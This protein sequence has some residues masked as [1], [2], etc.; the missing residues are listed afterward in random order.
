MFPYK[1]QSP[2]EH[3]RADKF[4]NI[5]ER[6]PSNAE[7]S[8]SHPSTPTSPTG[9]SS[10]E[11]FATPTHDSEA[12]F[13]GWSSLSQPRSRSLGEEAGPRNVSP[14]ST[15][16]ASYDVNS[17]QYTPFRTPEN[18]QVSAVKS[19]SPTAIPI[20]FRRP[21]PSVGFHRSSWVSAMS[22][23][24]ESPS[25]QTPRSRHSKGGST[26]F[27]PSK[28]FRPLYLV[29]RHG[30]RQMEAEDEEYPPLPLSRSTTRSPSLH[31]TEGVDLTH[32][33]DEGMIGADESEYPTH[34]LRIE[35]GFEPMS[36]EL[37]DSEQT[38]PKAAFATEAAATDHLHY[39]SLHQESGREVEKLRRFSESNVIEA[40][41]SLPSHHLELEHSLQ[42]TNNST[43]PPE[44]IPLP[45]EQDDELSLS[46][47]ETS[48]VDLA[49]PEPVT[50]GVGDTGIERSAVVDLHPRDEEFWESNKG[51]KGKGEKRKAKN[52]RQDIETISTLDDEKMHD[53]S[54]GALLE[55]PDLSLQTPIATPVDEVDDYVTSTSK[56][57]K[58]KKL[59][60][61]KEA[62]QQG[63]DLELA[64]TTV[65]EEVAREVPP[66]TTTFVLQTP[67]A[68][69]AAEMDDPIASAPQKEDNDVL[70]DSKGQSQQEE[71][72][73]QRMIS[74]HLED[75]DNEAASV[76]A[77]SSAATPSETPADEIG[78]FVGFTS[79]KKKGKQAKKLQFD[80]QQEAEVVVGSIA[81]HQ[82]ALRE[83]A[84]IPAIT[85]TDRGVDTRT[86]EVDDFT[87]LTSKKDKKAKKSKANKRQ[88]SQA[89]DNPTTD[90]LEAPNDK[91]PLQSA[92]PSVAVSVQTPADDIDEFLAF[93][94]KKKGKQAKKI[95]A[96]RLVD[97]ENTS[98]P[99][100]EYAGEEAPSAPAISPTATHFETPA[101]EF[102]DFSTSASKK[103]IRKPR[104][105]RLASSKMLT[106]SQLRP[107]SLDKT[108]LEKHRL[109][110]QPL[111]LPRSWISLLMMKTA[112]WPSLPRKRR[113]TR[114]TSR[115]QAK[116]NTSEEL[117]F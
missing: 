3:N 26:E 2:D 74:E 51:K 4:T 34:G 114:T 64:M 100:T 69:P 59:Q 35:T 68:T 95:K 66:E 32:E 43:L 117:L 57:K 110:L 17:K 22:T 8:P 94:S 71:G 49:K 9:T 63:V 30:A 6:G 84:S 23:S 50:F 16:S 18:F 55:R 10:A 82:E 88:D 27:K 73:T 111:I 80:K 92:E 79:K 13:G 12:I 58:G 83:E 85:S 89:M 33:N 97:I 105:R 102:V 101:E 62:K 47:P 104:D 65:P 67:L 19:P 93:T 60:K 112:S 86:D 70:K 113:K 46:G 31:S 11:D 21:R 78:D 45:V 72:V 77:F 25:P 75:V 52:Q 98:A 20:H 40:V 53:I 81:E 91:M 39:D 109:F 99:V 29:E 36:P 1:I 76:T 38:T 103:K 108:L 56:K 5:S 28:E 90:P 87:A 7:P 15:S 106:R 54:R 41:P 116:S 61:S 44:Q 107:Q 24:E 37:L 42:T 115:S 48:V 14:R 96:A